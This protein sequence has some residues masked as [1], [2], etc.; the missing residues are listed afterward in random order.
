MHFC[1]HII[2][3]WLSILPRNKHNYTSRSPTS[4]AFRNDDCIRIERLDE[5]K[6]DYSA[7]L[8]HIVNLFEGEEDKVKHIS[9]LPSSVVGCLGATLQYLAEFK[10]DGIVKMAG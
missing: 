9:S 10:L 7:S 3:S 6:F 5:S 4:Y 2:G 1:Q 8:K